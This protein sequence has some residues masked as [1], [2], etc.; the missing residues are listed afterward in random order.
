MTQT[1]REGGKLDYNF[2]QICDVNGNKLLGSQGSAITS[3]TD[4][5]GGTADDTVAAVS[6][7]GADAAINDN[8]AD[9]AAKQ[10]EILAALRAHG[11]ISS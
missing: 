5:S 11:L 4:N 3:I 1:K 7:S 6:G 8:F 2:E 9:L 10:E